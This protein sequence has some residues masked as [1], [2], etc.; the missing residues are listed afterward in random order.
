MLKQY[1]SLQQNELDTLSQQL[2]QQ[3]QLLQKEQQ[4]TQQLEHYLN[5]VSHGI[6]LKNVLQRQ[7][8]EGMQQQLQHLVKT[9][10]QQTHTAEQQLHET[11]SAFRKQYARIKGLE[12]IQQQREQQLNHKEEHRLRTTLDDLS[13]YRFK[14]HS[15]HR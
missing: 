10:H 3:Q 14:Q 6:D 8:C 12:K 9:Q 11:R 5:T 13:C 7:N 15:S 1:L 2:Q 4:R